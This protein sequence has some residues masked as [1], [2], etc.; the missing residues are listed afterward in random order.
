MRQRE[1]EESGMMSYEKGFDG[2]LLA[3]KVEGAHKS[4]N[5]DSLL[6]QEKEGN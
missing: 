5:V 2:P 6:K 1:A 3:L 4:R